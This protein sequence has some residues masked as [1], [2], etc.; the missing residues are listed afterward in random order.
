VLPTSDDDRQRFSNTDR[1]QDVAIVHD[2]DPA[3]L[4]LLVYQ[5][6]ALQGLDDVLAEAQEDGA[7]V[8]DDGKRLLLDMGD[9]SL[10]VRFVRNTK[11]GKFARFVVRR[12][13]A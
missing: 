13:D 12:E 8:E 4:P 7:L 9:G 1:V 11:A 3:V 10:T 6:S 2:A 5:A